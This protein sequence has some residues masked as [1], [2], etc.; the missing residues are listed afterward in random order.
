MRA[1][2][3]A[4]VDIPEFDE[5]KIAKSMETM[6]VEA[7]FRVIITDS[8]T[9]VFY[10][11][12]T[13]GGYTG[14]LLVYAPVTEVL[15]N[16]RNTSSFYSVDGEWIVEAAV[17]VIKSGNTIGSVLVTSSGDDVDGLISRIT[18]AILIFGI[19]IILFVFALGVFVA[20]VL[21][22]PIVKLTAFIKDMP[23][24]KLQKCDLVS[25]DEVGDLVTAFNELIDRVDELEEKRRAFVSDASHELKTPL[26]II[27]SCRIT[28]PCYHSHLR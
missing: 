1:N 19:I 20:T 3:V 15:I 21:T 18:L 6:P 25:R 26:S 7:G 23:K 2:I 4:S 17:P 14:K 27:R 5:K 9:K 22:N 24:D 13:E 28:L 12:Y 16:N 11:S 8:Q 10:D